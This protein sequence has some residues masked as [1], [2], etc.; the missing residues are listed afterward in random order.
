VMEIEM[1]Y[2]KPD[3]VWD[4]RTWLDAHKLPQTTADTLLEQ[5]ARCIGDV[6]MLVQECPELLV[7]LPALDQVKLK[8]AVVAATES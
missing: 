3:A 4:M 6:V 2:G 7:S 5:G 1:S 8:K